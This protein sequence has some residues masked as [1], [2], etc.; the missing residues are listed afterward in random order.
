MTTAKTY[1]SAGPRHLARV[2]AMLVALVAGHSAQAVVVNVVDPS[3]NPVAGFRWLLEEDNVHP[4]RFNPDGSG[5]HEPVDLTDVHNNA[6]SISIH[7]SHAEV[8]ANGETLTG[9]SATIDTS[10][11]ED[12]GITRF[13]LS[14]HPLPQERDSGPA[15]YTIGGTLFTADQDEVDVIVTPNPLPTAQIAIKVFED[16][17]P[18]NNNPDVTERGLAGFTIHLFDTLD[19]VFVDAFG[20]PLGTTYKQAPCDSGAG[21]SE[22]PYGFCLDADGAP[23]T[24]TLGNGVILTDDNGEA[25]VKYLSPGKYGVQAIA[26]TVDEGGNPVTWYQVTTIEGRRVSMPGYGRT[27]RRSSSSSVLRSGMPSTASC[28][29]STCRGRGPASPSAR[30]P[31]RCAKATSRARPRSSSSTARRR[32]PHAAWSG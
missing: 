19:R 2:A 26:P 27:S 22:S 25:F 20:N 28:A 30:S 11:F 14:V 24:D 18:L 4:V 31:A 21:E 32:R 17:A 16:N 3:G 8:L 6:L 10:E 15:E 1:L 7:R 23:V 5:V 29:R 9:S 13:L 12:K